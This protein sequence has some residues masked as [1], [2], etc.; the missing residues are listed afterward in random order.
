[1]PPA[2]AAPTWASVRSS[3]RIRALGLVGALLAAPAGAMAQTPQRVVSINLCTDQLAML[4]ADPGQLISVS[5]LASDPRSSA[6]V[7]EAAAY[8]LNRGRAE[9]IYLL[10]PDLVLAGRY[11]A[12]ATVAMLERLGI[13]VEIFDPAYGIADVTARLDQMGRALGQPDRAAALIADFEGELAAYRRDAGVRPRA[14]LYYAN[15]YTSG[16]KTLAGEILTA[17]G[18]SNI[19]AEEGISNGGTI[20]L[21]VLAM[22]QP[23]TVITSQTYPG[24]SRSEEVMAHPVIDA[25]R[26]THPGAAMMDSDWVC[27]TPF[28]LGAVADMVA[29]RRDVQ[30]AQ[31]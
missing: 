7:D 5:Y 31:R 24:G 18:L 1:M 29:L 6:M 12:T 21:E 25:L 28:V 17:A 14:A 3:S 30:D 19:A 2:G 13:R 15:G 23:D 9:A 8:P 26:L 10:Q 11:T 27:G 20:P 22:A 4:V 16:D